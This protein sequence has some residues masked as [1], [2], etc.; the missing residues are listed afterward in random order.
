M[1]DL[2]TLYKVKNSQIKTVLGSVPV[3]V[4]GTGIDIDILGSLKKPAS[5]SEME[6]IGPYV[7]DALTIVESGY[8]DFLSMPFYIAV[9]GTATDLVLEI[10]NVKLIEIGPIS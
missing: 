7:D 1:A 2:N 5:L 10:E 6:S 4:S 8:Y 9:S 3:R